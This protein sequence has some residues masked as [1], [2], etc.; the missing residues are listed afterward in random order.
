LVLLT[1]AAAAA[2][3]G[4]EKPCEETQTCIP[5]SSGGE[6][7]DGSG[8]TS[9]SGGSAGKGGSSALGGSAGKGGSSGKGGS[10]GTSGT[11]G[12]SGAGGSEGEPPTIVS[13]TPGDGSVDVERDVEVT[14]ELSEPIDAAT[15]TSTS[16]TLSGPD[17]EVA[18]SLSVVDN[19]IS[20]VAERPLHLLGT[21]TLTLAD[22]VADLDGDT[23]AE[24]ASAEFQVRDGRLSAPVFP[25]GTVPREVRAFGRN[26]LGDV[27]IGMNAPT[28]NTTVYGATYRA[29]DGTWTRAAELHSVTG[30]QFYANSAGIDAQGRAVVGWYPFSGAGGW[31]RFTEDGSWV[32]AGALPSLAAVDVSSAGTAIASWR[33]TM[34]TLVTQTLELSDGTAGSATPSTLNEDTYGSTVWSLDRAAII[35]YGDNDVVS[36]L[37]VEWKLASGWSP[38]EPLATGTFDSVAHQADEDGNIIVVWASEGEIWS[39]VYRQAQDDWLPAAFLAATP[40]VVQITRLD[41][42]AGNAIVYYRTGTPDPGSWAA[43]YQAGVGWVTSSIVRLDPALAFGAVALDSA[44][45]GLVVWNTPGKVRRYVSGSGWQPESPLGASTYANLWAAAALGGS[46]LFVS[47]EADGATVGAPYA[48][49]FE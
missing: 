22:T 49:R 19:V 36:D 7:G 20:F 15:V 39:R 26:E 18:G 35:A 9:G 13:F 5:I 24:S 16:V 6:A 40:L 28:G 3:C 25:F 2:A 33:D 31:S 47:S 4:E 14:A 30:G 32:D 11:S 34:G 45:N 48:V 42:T 29:L 41:M 21:Y 1:G 46:V 8:A 10:A 23:L 38:R 17:G 37:T 27:V 44:G 12:A 43:I